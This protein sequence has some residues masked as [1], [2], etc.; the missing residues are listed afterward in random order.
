M[1]HGR[2]LLFGVV[3]L[4]ALTYSFSSLDSTMKANTNQAYDES[5]TI[6]LSFNTD[7]NY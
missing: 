1:G 2:C 6:Q 4:E 7:N 5:S 3:G